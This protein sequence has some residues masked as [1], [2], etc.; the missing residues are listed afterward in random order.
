MIR[1][2]LVF[3]FAFAAVFSFVPE[4][5]AQISPGLHVARAADTFD[6]VNGVGGSLELSI[7][8]LP[9]DFFVAAEY[10]FPSCDDCSFWGG[11]ADV[12]LTLPIPLV[13][14]Y[15]TAGL[16]MRNTEASDTVVRTGGFGL[17]AGV[18]L[19]ALVV[20]GYFEGRYEIMDGSGDQLV[21]R[22]GLRL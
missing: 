2:F 1:Q 18:N 3:A 14:P 7:P 13:T 11:S 4:A 20:G 16:V 15:G 12:H 19:S 17:G 22:L 10:F 8:V 9:V 6:G 21:F 5:R